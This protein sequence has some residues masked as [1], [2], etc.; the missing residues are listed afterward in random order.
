MINDISQHSVATLFSCV[1][2]HDHYFITNLLLSQF[3]KIFLKSLNIWHSYG[4]ELI[5]SSAHMCAGAMSC[6]KMM[7]VL[8]IRRVAGR[9]VVTVSWY[10]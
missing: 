4:G 6:F 5:A 8:E 2:L 3:C 1:G 9:T 10:D 7:N